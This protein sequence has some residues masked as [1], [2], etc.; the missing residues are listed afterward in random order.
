MELLGLLSE[1][2]GLDTRQ[3]EILIKI[4]YFQSYGNIAELSR[5]VSIFSFFKN[6]TAKRVPKEKLSGQMLDLVSK[7][8]TETKMGLKQSLSL[9]LICLD[10]FKLVKQR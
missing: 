9:S 4:D 8:A 6:G 3:R 10:F 7:F 2:T 1:Y 5:M